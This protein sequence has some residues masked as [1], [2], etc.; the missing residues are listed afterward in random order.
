MYINDHYKDD[1]IGNNAPFY[2]PTK[3]NIEA[4]RD[5]LKLLRHAAGPDVFFSGCNV[6]QNMHSLGGSIGLVDSMRIGPDNGWEW[7]GVLTPVDH[8]SH[9]YF[10]NGRV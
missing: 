7:G 10:L 5:G 3:T 6:S 4:Y 8:G 1:P 2:D 9:L